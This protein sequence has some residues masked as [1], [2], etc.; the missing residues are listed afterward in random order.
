MTDTEKLQQE[1]DELRK[2]ASEKHTELLKHL[3]SQRKY[4]RFQDYNKNFGEFLT[5]ENLQFKEFE[6]N[7][8]LEVPLPKGTILDLMIKYGRW[9]EKN[10][11]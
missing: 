11:L 6:G 7:I 5:Q 10:S 2:Q 4:S 1:L 3:S 8:L 9:L